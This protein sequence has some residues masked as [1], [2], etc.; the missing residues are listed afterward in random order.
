MATEGF[1]NM[2]SEQRIIIAMLSKQIFREGIKS[3]SLPH[4]VMERPL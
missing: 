4:D 3:M 2:Q 1:H